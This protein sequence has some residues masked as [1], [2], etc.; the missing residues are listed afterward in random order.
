MNLADP[1]FITIVVAVATA[2]ALAYKYLK[3]KWAAAAK[4]LATTQFD[5]IAEAAVT[6]VYHDYVRD[7]KEAS[8]DGELT[9]EEKKKAL[10]SAVEAFKK[11]GKEQGLT[12]VM[13]LGEPI[14][15]LF[16]EK[17]IDR[18]KAEAAVGVIPAGVIP[19][20]G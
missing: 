20:P 12:A 2:L 10:A 13:S 3:P 11:I 5:E 17:A 8:T 1:L 18:R 16:L 4:F 15:K 19:V 14:I 6:Q 9:N 7:L